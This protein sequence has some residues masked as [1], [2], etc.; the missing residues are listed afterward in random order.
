MPRNLVCHIYPLLKTGTWIR[1]VQHLRARSELFD[2]QRIISVALGPGTAMPEEVLEAFGDFE[3][4]YRFVPNDE[5]LWEGA[6]FAGL[7]NAFA[8]APGET[9]Y[10]HSKGASH[11]ADHVSQRWADVMFHLCLDYPATVADT[12]RLCP[13]AGPCMR[14]EKRMN[15]EWHY[16]GTFFWFYES[17]IHSRAVRL[18]DRNCVERWPALNWE[19][20]VAGNLG[21][22]DCRNLY[23]EINWRSWITRRFQKEILWNEDR[24]SERSRC[25][26]NWEEI[27]ATVFQPLQVVYTEAIADKGATT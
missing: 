8:D 11:P 19:H 1:T 16:S 5:Q 3:A 25:P 4:V 24:R 17:A 21:L 14:V 2:G 22:M 20:T 10:C 12:L 18:D 13:I 15:V 7:L 27:P 6:S 9:F 23:D 26:T